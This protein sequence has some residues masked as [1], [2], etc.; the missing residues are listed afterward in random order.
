MVGIG[1]L[2]LVAAA[3]ANGSSAA[4]PKCSAAD[5]LK[6]GMLIALPNRRA[7]GPAR[8]V[9]RVGA[10]T[11]VMRG[12]SCERLDT[13]PTDALSRFRVTIGVFGAGATSR[14]IDFWWWQP[15]PPRAGRFRIA[16][17]SLEAPG[18]TGFLGRAFVTV[19]KGL[20]S[21]TFSFVDSRSAIR[22]TGSF[23]CR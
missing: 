8:A 12:G 18:T 10:T 23:T 17:T 22:I 14:G 11:Y 21:G 16:E 3:W 15:K 7:C 2:V 5:N 19:S 4:P 6:G 9:V 1:A 13:Q 20:N